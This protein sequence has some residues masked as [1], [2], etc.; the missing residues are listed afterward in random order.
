MVLL[1][2]CPMCGEDI[3]VGLVEDDA[4]RGMRAPALLDV[5]NEHVIGV[6]EMAVSGM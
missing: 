3:A 2:P 6:H 1:V 5:M 4:G